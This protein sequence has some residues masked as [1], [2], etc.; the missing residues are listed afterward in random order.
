M[1]TMEEFPFAKEAEDQLAQATAR[2]L[3]L[4]AEYLQILAATG[5]VEFDPEQMP[6]DPEDLVYL[7][8]AAIQVEPEQKQALLENE[9]ATSAI[10]ELA[11]IYRREL[12]YLRLMPKEDQG[13]FSLN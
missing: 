13:I 1:G 6:T 9:R 12:M 7:A 4:V 8:A 10:N 5:N 3:P 2:L 11:H